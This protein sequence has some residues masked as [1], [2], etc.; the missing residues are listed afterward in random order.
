MHS[1]RHNP[2][3]SYKYLLMEKELEVIEEEKD[4]GVMIDSELTFDLHI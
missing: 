4:I 1:G 2:D 3:E